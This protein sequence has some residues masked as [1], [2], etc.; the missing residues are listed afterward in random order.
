MIAM[1][2]IMLNISIELTKIYFWYNSKNKINVANNPPVEIL[3]ATSSD[4]SQIVEIEKECHLARWTAD[5]Y[6]KETARESSLILTA[7]YKTES[8]EREIA[9]FLTSRFAVPIELANKTKKYTELD[10]LNFGVLKKYRRQGIGGAL[11]DALI[12]RAAEM[13]VELIWL[14]VRESNLEAINLY[15]SKGFLA[16]QTRRNFYT[17]PLESALILK[18]A[19]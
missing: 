14:E 19:L 1:R 13:R 10:V 11:M 4:V 18:L 5:D 3:V 16:I 8:L 9:G 12:E 7:K 17:Q 6:Q 2:L 15:L